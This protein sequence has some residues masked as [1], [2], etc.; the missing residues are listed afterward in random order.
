VTLTEAEQEIARLRELL[1]NEQAIHRE[2]RTEIYSDSEFKVIFMRRQREQSD[3]RTM[4]Y[5][6]KLALEADERAR[7][8]EFEERCAAEQSIRNINNGIPTN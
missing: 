5:L 3:R 1:K 2:F 6:T 7:W 8:D 4:E